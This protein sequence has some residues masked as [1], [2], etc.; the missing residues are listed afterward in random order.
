L[1]VICAVT[2]AAVQIRRAASNAG[3]KSCGIRKQSVAELHFLSLQTTPNNNKQQPT[4]T[5]TTT[6]TATTSMGHVT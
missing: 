4:K 5:T 1:F 3:V 2:Q 6:A